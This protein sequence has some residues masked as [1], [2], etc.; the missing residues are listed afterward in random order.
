MSELTATDIFHM[1]SRGTVFSGLMQSGCILVGQRLELCSPTAKVPL[2]ARGIEKDRKLVARA[3]AGEM[4]AVLSAPIDL[5]LV[6]DGFYVD[7]QGT[8]HITSLK[9][10][11]SSIRRWWKFWVT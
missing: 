5:A 8:Y 2:V 11:G 1:S 7:E 10:V 9:L 6:S 3:T 4:V